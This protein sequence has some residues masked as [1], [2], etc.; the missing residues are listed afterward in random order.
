MH[1]QILQKETSNSPHKWFMNAYS[2]TLKKLKFV[3]VVYTLCVCVHAHAHMCTHTQLP[4]HVCIEIRGWPRCTPSSFTTVYLGT[5]IF[6]R[7]SEALWLESPG[8]L[9]CHL[10]STVAPDFYGGSE[11]L[12]AG[13]HACT[14]SLH[15]HTVASYSAT[16]KNKTF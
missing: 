13:A 2:T 14:A 10:L 5:G 11:D 6:T 9:Q 3:C 4:V 7:P 15:P 8:P 16:F 12:Y 1:I